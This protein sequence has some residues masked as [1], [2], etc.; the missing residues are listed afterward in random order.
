MLLDIVVNIIRKGRKV[1][2]VAMRLPD[3]TEN[4]EGK[5]LGVV[6]GLPAWVDQK[7]GGAGITRIESLDEA[8][9]VNLRDL[10]SG[11]YILYGYF[12]PYA[13]ANNVY[14]FSSS[15]LVNVITKEAGTHV[16]IFYPV[17]NVVQ[18]L[19]IMVDETAEGGYTAEQTNVYLNEL[20]KLLDTGTE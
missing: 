3:I 11:T 16:Q 6:N 20:N 4:D 17:N 12:R 9:L 7:S 1:E 14:T 8:N 10:A 19:A 13:G 15:L 5:V 2:E 18:F